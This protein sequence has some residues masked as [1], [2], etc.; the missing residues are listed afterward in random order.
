[1]SDSFI[2]PT[3]LCEA[4]SLGAGT[5]VGAFV[6][7]MA[8]AKIGAACEIENHAF[9]G[10]D[11]TLGD[12]VVI[13]GGVHLPAGMTVE[14]GVCIGQNAAFADSR[15]GQR[16]NDQP[17]ILRKGCVIGAN[18]TLCAGVTIG[19]EAVVD[20]GAVV[21]QSVQPFTIVAGNPAKVIG[22]AN[23]PEAH[24]EAPALPV[25]RPQSVESMVAGVRAYHLPFISDP[26]GN[27]TVG[28][29]ERS[30]P[31]IPKRYFL[32]FDV[33]NSHLRGEHAHKECHQF[34]ICVHGSCAVVVDNGTQ[35]EEF[36]L[37]RPT[38]GVHVPPMVWATEYKHSADSTLLVFASHYYD[39]DDYIR[40]YHAFLE[41]C[42]RIK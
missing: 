40:D 7:I 10:S 3:A 15:L 41:A 25:N 27:L 29:F 14:N 26:R 21:T 36:L 42:R 13:R 32:T 33:P 28:E 18:A 19:E 31:F 11:V 17:V 30:L 12:H 23:T 1:M 37:N 34:L 35:R 38:F 16:T 8:G 5:Q 22:F 24:V 20:A 9:I 6:Q 4:A 39:P 2:H